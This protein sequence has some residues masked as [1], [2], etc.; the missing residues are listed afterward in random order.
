MQ[1]RPLV[2]ALMKNLFWFQQIVKLNVQMANSS[3]AI[4]LISVIYQ[5]QY[6][7]WRLKLSIT[8]VPYAR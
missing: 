6:L 4:T 1:A 7:E 8:L 3:E 2:G 5:M